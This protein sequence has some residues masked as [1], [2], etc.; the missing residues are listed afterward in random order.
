MP[1]TNKN[2]GVVGSVYGRG[3]L[4]AYYAQPELWDL[5]RY[6]TNPDQRL[7]ARVIA[8]HCMVLPGVTIGDQ[9]VVGAG[10]VVTHDVTRG[11]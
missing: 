1:Q 3:Q 10:S 9:A 2:T 8:V 6:E 7:R 5:Q 4:E 11:A